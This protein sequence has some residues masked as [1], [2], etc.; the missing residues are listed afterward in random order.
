MLFTINSFN[1][2]EANL[3]CYFFLGNGE[4]CFYMKLLLTVLSVK[5]PDSARDSSLLTLPLLTVKKI[6][7]ASGVLSLRFLS[8]KEQASMFHHY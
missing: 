2:Q 3:L 6:F 4:V 1:P 8:A 5:V 7:H